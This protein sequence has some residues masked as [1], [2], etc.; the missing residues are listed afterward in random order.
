MLAEVRENFDVKNLTSF[1]IG[2]KI[3]KVYF[4]KSVDEFE[5]ILSCEKNV[6]V[7][8]NLSNTLVSTDGYDGVV[9]IT[10]KMNNYLWTE[11]S[12]Y[13]WAEAGCKG[14]MLARM[15]ENA[16][17][18]GF[19]FMIGFPGSL[20]G[21]IFMNAS[22]HGQCISDKLISVKCYSKEKGVFELSK[23]EMQFGYR[24]SICQKEDIYVLGAEFELGKKS[25][26]EIKMKMEEN[27]AFRKAHQPSL[28]LPNCGSVFRN[29][30]GN[31]AGRLLD[32]VGAKSFTSG[33]VKVW[34]NH[35][36]FIVNS[37]QTGTSTD[38]LE[39]MLKMFSS[40]KEKFEIEL[41]P[42]VRYL[43]NN[44]IREVELCKTLNIR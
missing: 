10:S 5:E 23:D 32:E 15:T 41:I 27:L 26:E 37:N 31:S 12:S 44:N 28:S 24:S 25:S 4:P 8:G 17:L 38:V 33:G 11:D 43:G 30:E 22:A 35:A 40:V 39:L 13:F 29:P 14:P 2:G 42:E 6:K 21:N 19:E 20:G 9:I 3:S 16:G 34:G 7:F 36:N 18:S 1:K